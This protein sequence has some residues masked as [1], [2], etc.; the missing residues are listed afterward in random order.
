MY[1]LTRFP[2]GITAARNE[3]RVATRASFWLSVLATSLNGEPSY[4]RY[5]FEEWPPPGTL[6][7]RNSTDSGRAGIRAPNQ[8]ASSCCCQVTSARTAPSGYSRPTLVRAYKTAISFPYNVYIVE[9]CGSTPE[10]TTFQR[11]GLLNAEIPPPSSARS[12]GLVETLEFGTVQPASIDESTKRLA[13]GR[14]I[15]A[16]SNGWAW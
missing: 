5:A 1:L 11:S 2:Q 14:F 4:R 7:L 16:P 13:N 12:F 8:R 3:R 9:L 10:V 6:T 15:A